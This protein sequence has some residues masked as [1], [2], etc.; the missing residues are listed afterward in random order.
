MTG[1]ENAPDQ[2]A[3]AV[4]EAPEADTA[5]ASAVPAFDVPAPE[6]VE[7]PDAESAIEDFE[8]PPPPAFDAAPP[9]PSADAI[10]PT[11][12][13]AP[14]SRDS[15]DSEPA[16]RRRGTW[17]PDDS[18]TSA[19]AHK[20]AASSRTPEQKAASR[21]AASRAATARDEAARR[22]IAR[23][24]DGGTE[25]NSYRGW[26]VAIYAGLAVLFFGAIGFMAFLGFPG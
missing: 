10:D 18:W 7:T 2:A 17:A 23:P 14:A 12:S 9:A 8:V 11:V 22:E 4:P 1:D 21:V 15:Q 25:G 6:S 20:N 13:S 19:S 16:L 5:A 24:S 26:T 3:D